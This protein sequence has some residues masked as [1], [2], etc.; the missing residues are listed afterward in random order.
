VGTLHGAHLSNRRYS[1]E[2]LCKT[3]EDLRPDAILV[4]LPASLMDGDGRPINRGRSDCPENWATDSV[5]TKLG[6]KQ[7][8]FDQPDRQEIFQKARY[9]QRE[10]QVNALLS[11]WSAEVRTHNQPASDLNTILVF[12]SIL[13]AQRNFSA[14]GGPE[15]INSKGHDE[16]IR[17]K[18]TLMYD[19]LPVLAGQRS[20]Y[21]AIA[22]E[23]AFFKDH[24]EQ[25]NRAMVDHVL[26]AAGD[27]RGKP[28]SSCARRNWMRSARPHTSPP[29][30]PP[31][32]ASE[33]ARV[34]QA[35]ALRPAGSGIKGEIE[36]TG[37]TSNGRT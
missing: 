6:I 16:L 29:C 13:S 7:I 32:R 5:A 36:V 27:H 14:T 22:S 24:W 10:A 11:Q 12:G 26:K 28:K 20:G 23:Q 8:P 34:P 17:A 1:P 9:S 33:F 35:S 15:T 25:R 3:L 30:G 4:E 2:I 37:V 18:H 31:R 21:E 19:V